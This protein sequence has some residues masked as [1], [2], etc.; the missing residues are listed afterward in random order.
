VIVV[1]LEGLEIFGRHGV[2]EDERRDGR[3]FYYDLRLEVSEAALSDRIEDTVDYRE[4]ATCVQKVSDGRQFQLLE[5]LAAAVADEIAARFAVERVRVRVRK[6]D[7]RP[8]GLPVAY[9]AA[10]AE[11]GSSASRS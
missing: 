5:A 6:P 7:P 11:R 8:A 9:S 10:T 4:V 3:T 1:E 2:E